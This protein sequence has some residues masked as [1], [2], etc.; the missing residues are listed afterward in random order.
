MS[1][2]ARPAWCNYVDRHR[3]SNSNLRRDASRAS[4]SDHGR[5]SRAGNGRSL[6]SEGRLVRREGLGS[7]RSRTGSADQSSQ[8][9][10]SRAHSRAK[11]TP[12]CIFY[13]SCGKAITAPTFGSMPYSFDLI[14][15]LPKDDIKGDIFIRCPITGQPVPTGLHTGTVVFHT[16]PKIK[17]R[18]HCPACQKDHWWNCT[19]AWVV[20]S[21]QP[22]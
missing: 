17:I 6:T 13:R 12:P 11:T 3:R 18:M 14:L 21:T 4:W 5:K 19:E 22:N 2:T 15:S 20:E 10:L 1:C 16:L 9:Q 8:R 7:C